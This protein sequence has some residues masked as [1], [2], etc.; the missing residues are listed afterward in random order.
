MKVKKRLQYVDREVTIMNGKGKRIFLDL[1]TS[2]YISV[3]SV[4]DLT[5]C[6]VSSTKHN[7]E[8][9]SADTLDTV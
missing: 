2:T 5:N 3:G 8:Y 1:S 4:Q 6:G 7:A 9:V